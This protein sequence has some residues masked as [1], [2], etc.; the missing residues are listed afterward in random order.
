MEHYIPSKTII[1]VGYYLGHR[2]IEIIGS[3]Y[4][5]VDAHIV[6]LPKLNLTNE[7]NRVEVVVAHRRSR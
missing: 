2:S 1:C 4:A 7:V 6:V 3:V 5:K